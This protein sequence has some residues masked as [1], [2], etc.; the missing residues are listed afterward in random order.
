MKYLVMKMNDVEREFLSILLNHPELINSTIVKSDFFENKTF[1]KIFEIINET[2]QFDPVGFVE[3]GFE[4]MDLLLM[5]HQSFIFNNAY[6]SIFKN[7]ELKIINHHKTVLLDALNL[8]LSKRQIDYE[9]Y[10]KEFDKIDDIKPISTKEHPSEKEIVNILT[11]KDK[12]I[13]LGK[14]ERTEK[15]LRL[16][17]DDLVTVAG[18]PGFGKSAFLLNIFNECLADQNNY[19][20]YYNLE[21]NDEQVIKRL[22]AIDSRE[23][24][25]D[26]QKIKEKETIQRSVKKYSSSNYYIYN[27]SSMW[28]RMQ[29]SIISHLK[30]DK[31]NIVF[32]DHL[33]LIGLENRNFNKTDYERVTYI[34][35]QLRKLCR[36]YKVLVF[37]AS[38]CDRSSLRNGKITLHSLKDSGEI[39][40]S[41]TH[42]ILLYESEDKQTDFEFC[43]NVVI[44]IAKNRN[45]FT[46]KI[47]V[48]FIK[49]KQLF[50]EK[51]T[52]KKE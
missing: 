12:Y 34:M 19:C 45:N 31:K 5:I 15:V 46:Y 43:T 39:E 27:D 17:E 13:R 4:D 6:M 10:K 30:K 41:S 47:P 24:I 48:N 32:I 50:F 23:K 26:L 25:I 35:K 52:N 8:K 36:R 28:E 21:I 33:G 16:L 11:K 14:F 44:D 22:I 37:I 42:V 49:N 1:G 38:Q 2:K 7:D 29:A 40:N 9:S 20:Q 3:K 51:K 18:P